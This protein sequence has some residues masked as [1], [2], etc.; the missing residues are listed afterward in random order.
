MKLDLSENNL[1]Y[2]TAA[3]AQICLNMSFYNRKF[4]FIMFTMNFDSNFF[5]LIKKSI[6]VEV[7]TTK[8]IL[9]K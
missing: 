8:H 2:I 6:P 5:Q 9:N 7:I 4:L 3:G 1:L